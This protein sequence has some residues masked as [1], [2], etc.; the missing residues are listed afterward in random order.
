[1]VLATKIIIIHTTFLS[2]IT[3]YIVSIFT[4]KFICPLCS[5]TQGDKAFTTFNFNRL[6]IHYG[7]NRIENF[8]LSC[9]INEC[10]KRFTSS[11]NLFMLRISLIEEL[12]SLPKKY[13]SLNIFLMKMICSEIRSI[14]L[15]L[16]TLSVKRTLMIL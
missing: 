5:S 6:L 2:K 15:I 1:M 8:N 10:K 13:W 16:R 4:M 7:N 12:N 3:V 9:S 11:I 14:T